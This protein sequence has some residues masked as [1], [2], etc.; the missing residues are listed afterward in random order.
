MMLC[1]F[2]PLLANFPLCI[3]WK[4][5]LHVVWLECWTAVF[6]IHSAIS[7]TT[8]VPSRACVAVEMAFG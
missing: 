8:G 1:K 7:G 6:L 5:S 2:A 3:H 4:V